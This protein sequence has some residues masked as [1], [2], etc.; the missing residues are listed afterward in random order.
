[1]NH[2][3]PSKQD[4][5]RHP[6]VPFEVKPGAPASDILDRMRM[7]SFQGRQ[8][9][10]VY[11]VW[12]EMLADNTLIL[13]GLAGAMVPAGMRRIFA[14]L[15]QNR[16]IDCVVSTG[17]NLFHDLH[18]SLGRYHYL[19]HPEMD[20]TLLREYG[21]DRI[22]DT[23]A[24]DHEFQQTDR[25]IVDYAR[26]L[27]PDRAYSTREF[28]EGLGAMLT[29]VARE[30][31]IITSA[32]KQGVP[33]YC[34]AISDSSYGIALSTMD[35]RESKVTFD[36]IADVRELAVLV[37]R[38]EK[39]GIIFI[40]GGT[41]KNFIQQAEVTAQ[42]I[43]WPAEGHHYAV[44]ITTDVPQWGGLSGCTFSESHSWGKIHRDAPKVAAY[45]DATIALPIL[46]TALAEQE[47][48]I[49]SRK[50]PTLRF[51]PPE[52]D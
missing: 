6:T 11:R 4:L 18:E 40:G 33:I 19:G 51:D 26:T 35:P 21:I 3:K 43:G 37:S 2:R 48:L 22:Y 42:L 5:L 34:P 30:E 32:Y 13:F 38:A 25:F 15:I 36:M 14:Y 47:E 45:M 46:A 9:A 23:Y 10:E 1:M 16:L 17:A 44:Q 12:K 39:T 7:I 27:D 24:D 29:P 31:G 52:S 49:K 8:L 20:D 28:F 41:P 50:M